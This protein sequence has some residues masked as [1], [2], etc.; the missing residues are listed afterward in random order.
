MD[1]RLRE[2]FL[3]ERYKFILQQ[4]QALNK[5]TFQ[6]VTFFQSGLGLILSAH[7]VLGVAIAEKKIGVGWG[8]LALGGVRWLL[9]VLSVF[10]ILM[11]LS[12]MASWIGYRKDEAD[13]EGSFLA[14]ARPLPSMKNLL[15]WY[16]TYVLLAMCAATLG[17]F[18]FFHQLNDLMLAS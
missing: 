2:E 4:K 8:A 15:R 9:V 14:V 11:I 10:S 13:I 18:L 3:L 5:T 7:Y 6:L 1:S 12:G 17:Y 16:E